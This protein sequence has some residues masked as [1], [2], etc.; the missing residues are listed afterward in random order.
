MKPFFEDMRQPLDKVERHWVR[1]PVTL[2]LAPM[3]FC[4]F[5]LAGIFDGV[6]AWFETVGECLK[7][8]ED[9]SK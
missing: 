7:G 4:F 8:T 9:A 6:G 3:F 5:I 2:V 1:I